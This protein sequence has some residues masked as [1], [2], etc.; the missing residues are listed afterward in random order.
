[1]HRNGLAQAD[2]PLTVQLVAVPFT[3]RQPEMQLLLKNLGF[4]IAPVHVRT[5]P[6]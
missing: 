4:I 2:Q 5:S 6:G 1:M 3:V